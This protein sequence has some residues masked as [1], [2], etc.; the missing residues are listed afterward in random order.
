MFRGE[1]MTQAT[2]RC[3][4]P[5]KEQKALTIALQGPS[6]PKPTHSQKWRRLR[7]GMH[8]QNISCQ[9]TPGTQQ[10]PTCSGPGDPCAGFLEARMLVLVAQLGQTRPRPWWSSKPESSLN[11]AG[12]F[13]VQAT[14]GWTGHLPPSILGLPC[15]LSLCTLLQSRSS[16]LAQGGEHLGGLDSV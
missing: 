4:S 13:L 3:P 15:L 11:P 2:E 5:W 14:Q 10:A 6:T 9:L 16:L 12:L 1:S 7:R 8:K